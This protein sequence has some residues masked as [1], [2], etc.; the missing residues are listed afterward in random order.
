MMIRLRDER[1]VAMV[2]ALLV[3]MVVFMLSTVVVAQSLHS[4]TSSG[5]DRERLLSVNI[6]ESGTNAWWAYLQTTS[7]VGT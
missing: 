7:A 6:A 4:V 5:Y 3:T 1:G 2:V